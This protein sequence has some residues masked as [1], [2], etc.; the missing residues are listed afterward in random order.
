MPS[1]TPASDAN[2]RTDSAETAEIVWRIGGACGYN[3]AGKGI[4]VLAVWG[5]GGVAVGD[6]NVGDGL[7]GCGMGREDRANYRVAR[8]GDRS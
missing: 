4:G 1:A 3:G 6:G 5:L 7:G 8:W 2:R